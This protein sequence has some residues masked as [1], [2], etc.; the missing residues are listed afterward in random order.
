MVKLYVRRTFEIDCK[1]N[2]GFPY[3]F[4]LSYNDKCQAVKIETFRRV[5]RLTNALTL[6]L[7]TI[8]P[9][10]ITYKHLG[11]IVMAL[12]KIDINCFCR[13]FY[14]FTPIRGVGT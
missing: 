13:L 10:M 9:I 8:P 12:A 5:S 6:D 3:G 4:P 2:I 11:L 7:P 1:M 14:E